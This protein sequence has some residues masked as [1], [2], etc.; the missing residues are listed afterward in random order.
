MASGGYPGS[1]ATGLP[2]TGLEDVDD[3]VVVFHAGTR[4][5]EDGTVVT[6][7]GRV[8]G[9][10]ATGPTLEAARQ[11]AY[12]NVERIHFEG[13]HYRRDIGLKPEA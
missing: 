10:T 11:K 1:Y 12:A 9:V 6:A 4:R 5:R 2:I 3:D 13:A 8:L 7:G